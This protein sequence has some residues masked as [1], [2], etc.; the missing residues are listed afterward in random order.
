MNKKGKNKKGKPNPVPVQQD[1]SG[2][3]VEDVGVPVGDKKDLVGLITDIIPNLEEKVENLKE[4]RVPEIV[5]DIITPAVDVKDEETPKKPK[6]NRGKKKK[7]K[8]D[9]LEDNLDEPKETD[10]QPLVEEP[11]VEILDVESKTEELPPITPTARKKK[12]KKK[13]ADQKVEEVFSLDQ[14]LPI[15]PIEKEIKETETKES[16]PDITQEFLKTD[17]LECEVKSSKKKNKK[18]KRTDSEKSDK[19]EF[20]CTAA[21]QKILDDKDEHEVKMEEKIDESIISLEGVKADVKKFETKIEKTEETLPLQPVIEKALTPIRDVEETKE[22]PVPEGKGKKKNKKDKKQTPRLEEIPNV[23]QSK[24]EET[25]AVIDFETLAQSVVPEQIKDVPTS[26][27]EDKG[28]D[29]AI[30][31]S[32]EPLIGDLSPKPKAKIAK[33]VEKKRK[34]KHETSES[35]PQ[36][37]HDPQFVKVEDDPFKVK[38][39]IVEPEPLKLGKPVDVEPQTKE[40]EL[41]SDI[42]CKTP[43]EDEKLIAQEFE[44][45]AEKAMGKKRKKGSKVPKA[46]D[47]SSGIQEQKLESDV[48]Q[49]EVKETTKEQLA[50]ITEILTPQ[51]E[52]QEFVIMSE[53]SDMPSTVDTVKD[54]TEEALKPGVPEFQ[55]KILLTPE[56]ITEEMEFTKTEETTQPTED[57]QKTET[58]SSKKRKKSPKPPKKTGEFTKTEERAITPKPEVAAQETSKSEDIT[59]Q[60]LAEKVEASNITKMYDIEISSIRPSESAG[61]VSDIVPDITYPRASSQ[62]LRDDNNNTVISEIFPVP[63]LDVPLIQESAQALKKS[64]EKKTSPKEEKT[65]IKSKMMEV[66]QDM[67][68]LR[69]SIERSLAELT[70]M[71]KS[72]D[73]IEKEFE[74]TRTKAKN[75]SS[76]LFGTDES[77]TKQM[78]SVEEKGN[79]KIPL[80]EAAVSIPIEEYE[81]P[82]AIKDSNKQKSEEKPKPEERKSKKD[83]SKKHHTEEKKIALPTVESKVAEPLPESKIIETPPKVENKTITDT[84]AEAMLSI[85][86]PLTEPQKVVESFM[87]PIPLPPVEEKKTEIPDTEKKDAEKPKEQITETPT[88]V[89]PVCPSRKDNKG[90]NKKKKGKQDTQMT[91]TTQSTPTTAQSQSTQET[92]KEEK[93]ESKTEDKSKTKDKSESTEKGKQQASNVDSETPDEVLPDLDYEPID[94][95]EDALTSSTDDVNKTF[96]M[97]I[98]ESQQQNNPKINIIAPDEE[99]TPVSPPKNLLGHPDIPVRSNK[100]DFKKEKDKIPN[101]ITARVKIK[102][103]VEVER[104]QT[105]NTQ[106]NNK[107][108]EFCKDYKMDDNNDFVYKYSF[109]KVFLQSSC[110]VCKKSLS[111]SRV[112]C[113]YCNLLFYCSSKHKDD[114]WPQ[115]QA[116][117]FAVST[118]VHLKGNLYLLV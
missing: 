93:T 115:H 55:G 21:F 26:S 105:K 24:S 53:K 47:I 51:V 38:L 7:G 108:K 83:K 59:Q 65:D 33:P 96:E 23:V 4:E 77:T 100:R 28:K 82:T 54:I 98:K 91:A 19:E 12:N 14:E 39:E 95:F 72:E 11:K 20:S 18:K 66:N 111:G 30:T 118:I 15:I 110:H 3:Q 81:I 80:V 70:S 84:P 61:S 29:I 27:L 41:T 8:D 31:E 5:S 9:D 68:E 76:L 107:M 103:S 2:E 94:N 60:S 74:A 63:I 57:K 85:D 52:Q 37:T 106:T 16:V 62:Q 58:K 73:A 43:D 44:L 97:I 79:D 32:P 56:N 45:L 109:R 75:V 13:N 112:P 117:C 89:P 35:L 86:Q 88:D 64:E 10:I 22:G 36:D 34:E 116:L 69:L 113:S 49:P 102:D 6:R 50:V 87:P 46:L 78:P 48:K 25:S 90:K 99:K 71:E 42:I 1:K 40:L 101:E 17:V 114:D 92:K 67:E 104:K